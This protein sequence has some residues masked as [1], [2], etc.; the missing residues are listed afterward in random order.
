MEDTEIINLWKAQNAKIE[1]S[2]RINKQLLKEVTNQKA[3]AALQPLL[4]HKVTGIVAAILWQIVL[5]WG[6]ALA[7]MYYSP[8]AIYFIV[9]VAAMFI[10]NLKAIMDYIRHLYMAKQIRYD[11]SV[12]DIQQQLLDIELSIVKHGKIMCLQFPF[13]TTFFLSSNWFPHTV[14][15]GYLVFQVVL[16]GSF[17]Y[18]SYWLYKNH[19]PENLDKKWFQTLL[20]G[21]G[22]GSVRKALAVYKELN[23]Y[24]EEERLA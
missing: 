19:T 16:T 13:F 7:F 14:G 12:L 24:N 1:Q 11:G 6:L 10:I 9:S 2:L 22:G 8:A 17:T 15:W 4:Y 23:E 20:S 5:G 21:S 18:L 3:K